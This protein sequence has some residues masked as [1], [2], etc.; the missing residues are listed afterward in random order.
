[1]KRPAQVHAHDRRPGAGDAH[2]PAADHRRGRG[3]LRRRRGNPRH[4]QRPAARDAGR[5]N[6]VSVHPRRPVRRGHGRVRDPAAADRAWPSRR[7]ALHRP[8]HDQRGGLAWGFFNRI[9]EDP[10]PR[11]NALARTSRP[12]RRSPMRSPSASSKPSGSVASIRRWKWKREAQARCMETN[13][14]KR[15]YEAFANKRTP[16]FEGN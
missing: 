14:F 1:M 8:R 12:A 15:A 7:A 9:V 2:L 11:R 10:L 5:Q 16:V 13:D 4:G 6:R 3:R